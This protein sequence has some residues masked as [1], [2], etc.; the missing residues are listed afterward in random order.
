MPSAA[1]ASPAAFS[2]FPALVFGSSW[3][4]TALPRDLL[5]QALHFCF[6]NSFLTRDFEETPEE[7]EFL[8]KYLQQRNFPTLALIAPGHEEFKKQQSRGAISEVLN[9]E[10]PDVAPTAEDLHDLSD[11]DVAQLLLESKRL[12][13]DLQRKGQRLRTGTEVV[14]PTQGVLVTVCHFRHYWNSARA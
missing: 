10:E 1:W 11:Y 4:K 13:A 9:R 5:L 3:P 14:K 8:N 7:L 2:S 6:R 12:R